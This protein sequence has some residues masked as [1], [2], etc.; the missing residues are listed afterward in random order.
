MIKE[1]RGMISAEMVA[2]Y[3]P[4]IPCLIPGE[5]I[6]AEVVE[7]LI[8]LKLRRI[9]VHGLRDRGLQSIQVVI[10]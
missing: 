2:A 1:S 10:K 9:P 7:Y 6:T 5:I 8:Y 3:P 4:G